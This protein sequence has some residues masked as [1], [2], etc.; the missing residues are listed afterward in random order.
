MFRKWLKVYDKVGSFMTESYNSIEI[1]AN[2][3]EKLTIG[4]IYKNFGKERF[5]IRANRA[6]FV[7]TDDSYFL[8]PF[9][10]PESKDNFCTMIDS[11]FRLKKNGK[12]N[13]QFI[14]GLL[15]CEIKSI[16]WNGKKTRIMFSAPEYNEQVELT[17]N[18]NLLKS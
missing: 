14:H 3:L 6:H 7:E 1:K 11:P 10:Y 2:E 12:E 18:E 4:K 5:V 9:E 8:F 17:V 15:M 16:E 13:Y